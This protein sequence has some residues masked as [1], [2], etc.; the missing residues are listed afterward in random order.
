MKCALIYTSVFGRE[1]LIL[2]WFIKK[3]PVNLN[4]FSAVRIISKT[5]SSVQEE[6]Q[7][8]A[9]SFFFLSKGVILLCE[10]LLFHLKMKIYVKQHEYVKNKSPDIF[11]LTDQSYKKN[12]SKN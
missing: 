3:K 10:L 11:V 1:W 4:I 9:N 5:S 8:T 6:K 12:G 2:D 7:L